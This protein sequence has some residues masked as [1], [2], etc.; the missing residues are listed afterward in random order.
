MSK[1]KFGTVEV[2][3]STWI[4][5]EDRFVLR[6]MKKKAALR[7]K[8]GRASPIDWLAVGLAL[9]DP[10]HNIIDDEVDLQEVQV[11]KPSAVFARLSTSESAEL[12]QRITEYTMLESFKG[13]RDYWVSLGTICKDRQKRAAS[14]STMRGS[15]GVA[16]D[17]SKLLGPK[18]FEEL[19]KLEGQIEAKLATNGTIDVEYWEHLLNTLLTYKEKAKLR[20]L[21]NALIEPRL[22]ALRKQQA[23]LA[24][25]WQ[26]KLDHSRANAPNPAAN[27]V[28]TESSL[29]PE[30]ML[31]LR[32]ED[33][34]LE[35][36]TGDEFEKK[37]ARERGKVHNSDHIP[38]FGR[39][40]D[41]DRP[42]RPA[43]EQTV[44]SASPQQSAFDLQIARGLRDNEE[45]F[46]AEVAVTTKNMSTWSSQYRPRKPQYFNRVIKGYEWNK[47]NQTHYDQ[48]HPPP[49][50]VQGYSFNIFY[51]DLV[52]K[53]KTPSYRIERDHVRR[54]GEMNAPAGEDDTCVIR[55]TAGAPY[56]DI[57]FRIVDREWDYSAKHDRGFRCSFDKSIL[58]LHFQFKKIF[59][60][61]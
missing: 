50:V 8:N 30:P 27:V 5:D 48:E 17:L 35:S 1:R 34:A 26:D 24:A 18:S 29:D 28:P 7:A 51:P 3:E 54:R 11:K 36:M 52:N 2:Q 10:D 59:Y 19:Q 32:T 39:L 31:C 38:T 58:Q 9:V 20:E 6:Q 12:D 57:A 42:E 45:I 44:R 46:D 16:A 41:P 55:F 22:S 15:E 56:E 49:R 25:V 33:Q 4:A 21:D 37:V 23:H 13:N 61:K 47:Y 43:K 40:I 53:M 14:R 60:R